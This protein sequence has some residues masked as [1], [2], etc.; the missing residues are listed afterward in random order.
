M[1]AGR[2]K[3]HQPDHCANC[4]E[5]AVLGMRLRTAGPELIP[6][7]ARPRDD[8]IAAHFQNHPAPRLIINNR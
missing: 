4:R 2:R 5:S 8:G 3:Q 6:H 7:E 1:T